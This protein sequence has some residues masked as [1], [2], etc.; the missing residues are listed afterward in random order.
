MINTY[1]NATSIKVLKK[2]AMLSIQLNSMND[3]V[4]FHK[5][6]QQRAKAIKKLN[7]KYDN[8]DTNKPTRS[9][10]EEKRTEMANRDE[11]KL[12]GKIDN[13]WSRTVSSEES[14]T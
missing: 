10:V 2:S 7:P 6:C 1:N 9:Y 11:A 13:E 14:A 5:V 3:S 12:L 8:G 4:D